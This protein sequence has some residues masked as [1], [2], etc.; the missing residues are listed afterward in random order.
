MEAPLL[1]YLRKQV[2]VMQNEQRWSLYKSAL[3]LAYS[4][5]PVGPS[6]PVPLFPISSPPFLL[7]LVLVLVQ[8]RSL[9]SSFDG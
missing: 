3:P 7:S 8:A 1:S 6:W 4:T 5:Q 2:S 9:Y